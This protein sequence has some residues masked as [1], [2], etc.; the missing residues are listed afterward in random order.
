MLVQRLVREC[1]L[2]HIILQGCILLPIS[3]HRLQTAACS[4]SH[5][6]LALGSCLGLV[7]RPSHVIAWKKREILGVVASPACLSS[8]RSRRRLGFRRSWKGEALSFR[9]MCHSSWQAQSS[10]INTCSSTI[11]DSSKLLLPQLTSYIHRGLPIS[12]NIHYSERKLLYLVKTSTQYA[13]CY[14]APNCR[15]CSR[16]PYSQATFTDLTLFVQHQ[17]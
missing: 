16:S 4:S 2:Q 8:W 3:L 5:K 15:V 6:P 9:L 12:F 13:W 14:I 11:S 17:Q 10:H 7:E 1:V